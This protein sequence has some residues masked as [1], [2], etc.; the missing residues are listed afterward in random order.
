MANKPH[1]RR[2]G[3]LWHRAHV[4]MFAARVFRALSVRG[5]SM[6][7]EEILAQVS[8]VQYAGEDWVAWRATKKL[9][10]PFTGPWAGPFDCWGTLGRARLALAREG[11]KLVKCPR[12]VADT[13][14]AVIG[15]A[16]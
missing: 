13:G 9:V 3:Q 10:A 8:R 6:T 2:A 7:N 5:L 12:A 15:G 14:P 16:A 4:L 11:F 1:H